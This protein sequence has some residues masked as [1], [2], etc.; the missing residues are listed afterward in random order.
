M[1][2]ITVRDLREQSGDV[3]QRVDGGEEFVVTR[4]GKPIALLVP[5]APADV[6]RRLRAVRASQWGDALER[7]QTQAAATGGAWSE[8]DI[9]AEI[10]AARAATPNAPRPTAA[11]T[12]A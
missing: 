7:M 12:Q 4:N 1:D 9:Q 8:A 3:W 5:V 6:E 2:Y 11:T 10:A